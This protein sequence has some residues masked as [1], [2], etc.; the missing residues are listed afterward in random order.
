MCSNSAPAALAA[1]SEG[2]YVSIPSGTTT[3]TVYIHDGPGEPPLTVPLVGEYL[4]RFE[5]RPEGW[6]I[7]E[8]RARPIFPPPA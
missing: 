6:R 3:Y 2:Q 8:R 5:R 7:A 1:G 4:D